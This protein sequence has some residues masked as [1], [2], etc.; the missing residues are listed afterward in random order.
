[1]SFDRKKRVENLK[2]SWELY[3]AINTYI[4][5]EVDKQFKN[6]FE[7]EVELTKEMIAMMPQKIDKVNYGQMN[8]F[9]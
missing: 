4:D 8:F 5:T 6:C 3:K 1:M 7:K 9:D 2:E